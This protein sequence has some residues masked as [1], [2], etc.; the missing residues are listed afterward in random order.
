MVERLPAGIHFDKWR[1]LSGALSAE[2]VVLGSHFFSIELK[3]SFQ[4]SLWI[5][6]QTSTGGIR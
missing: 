5:S 1:I 4:N 2:K 6:L 3:K